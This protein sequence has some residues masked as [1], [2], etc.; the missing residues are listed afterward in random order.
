MKGDFQS[1]VNV[2]QA[3]GVEGDYCDKNPRYSFDAG[4]G[5]LI[6]GPNGAIVGRFAWATAPFD[7]DG[8]PS[9][10]S[11][12]GAG[13]VS[14]FIHREQQG[15]VVDYLASSGLKVQPGFG[16]TLMIGGGFW[17]YNAGS[18]EALPGMKAYANYADGKVTFAATGTPANGG[19]TT[20]TI[21]AGA[22]SFTG[23]IAD[24]ILTASAVTGLIVPGEIIAGSGVITG[25]QIVAQLSG[26][27]NGAGTYRLSIDSQTVA[28]EAMTGSYGLFTAV[29]ALAGTFGVGQPLA[30]SGGGGVAAG[31]VITGLGTGTGG[32]GTYY[33]NLT[34]T[35]TSST[36]TSASNVETKWYARSTGLPGE[37]V[38]ISDQ[39]LG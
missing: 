7:G 28:S 1:Q 14:G 23:V 24:D 31:T 2:A 11:N 4:P 17:A 12:T 15:L 34:Q 20:G 19:S 39:P 10:V 26:T 6:A 37:V 36:I 16:T 30:G 18:N 25:T 35:V 29:S 3:P 13:P 32:L 21:A 8:T 38:K 27:A 33:V 5:G 22:A 9:S